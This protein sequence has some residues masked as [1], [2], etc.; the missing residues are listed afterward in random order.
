M[1]DDYRFIL[2]YFDCYKIEVF[3][4]YILNC[5]EDIIAGYDY[6]PDF[7]SAFIEVSTSP[8]ISRLYPPLKSF[9]FV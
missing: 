3:A 5:H 6:L 4:S 1:I 7:E 9:G 8:I 2:G